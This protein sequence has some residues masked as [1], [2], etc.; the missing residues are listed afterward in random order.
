MLFS[1]VRLAGISGKT[2]GS[3]KWFDMK[4]GFGFITPK[5][6]SGVEGDVFVHQT[7]IQSATGFRSLVDGQEV[8]FVPRPGKSGKTEAFEVSMPDGSPVKLS[9]SDTRR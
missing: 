9:M 5:E 6:G 3:V 4:K 7:N 1:K 2:F 8:A